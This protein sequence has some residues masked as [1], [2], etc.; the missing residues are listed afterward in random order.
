MMV[1]TL[2]KQPIKTLWITT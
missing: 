2:H 1:G